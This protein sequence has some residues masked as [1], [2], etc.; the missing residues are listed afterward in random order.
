MAK[1]AARKVWIRP[2]LKRIGEIKDVAQGSG[3]VVQGQPNR[4]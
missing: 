3:S 4:S 1:E 2:E